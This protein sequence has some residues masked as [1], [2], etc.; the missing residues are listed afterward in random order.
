MKISLFGHNGLLGQSLYKNSQKFNF[1]IQHLS[2]QEINDPNILK[3]KLKR[4]LPDVIICTIAIPSNRRCVENPLDGLMSNLCIPMSILR[5][6]KEFSIKC[7]IFSSHGVYSPRNNLSEFTEN[8]IPNPNTFYGF[9]KRELE[10]SAINL[11][12]DNLTVIRLPSLYGNRDG[13]GVLGLCE[14]LIK[15]LKFNDRIEINSLIYDTYTYVDDVSNF[16]LKNLSEITRY[17]YLHLSNSGIVSLSEFINFAK[18]NLNSS[19]KISIMPTN[20][21]DKV[22][23][24]AL[25]SIYLDKFKPLRNWKEAL[26][27]FLNQH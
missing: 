17:Q 4:F 8:D 7:L 21:K 20:N 18:E 6:A 24:N 15:K 25:K 11:L 5:V 22:S 10:L 9:L 19:S 3:K 27:D 14:K 1:E 23:C 26:I 16:I 13:I 2:R 12:N